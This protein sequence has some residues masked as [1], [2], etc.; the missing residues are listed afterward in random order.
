V[1][2]L[3]TFQDLQI[4]SCAAQVLDDGRVT[5]S[6]GRTVSFKNAIIIMTS[7]LGSAAI[8]EG[9]ASNPEAVKETVMQLARPC[10][11][12]LPLGPASGLRRS[13]G[14]RR[15]PMSVHACARACL[16]LSSACSRA[17]PP[18]HISRLSRVHG[19][20]RGCWC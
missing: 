12:A 11:P 5:D 2:D 6:Q 19:P 14:P 17:V 4:R 18:P 7:N 20:G 3:C 15:P 13:A 9:V 16:Y 1:E 10:A 8:L